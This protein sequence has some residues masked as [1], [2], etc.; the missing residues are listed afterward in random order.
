MLLASSFDMMNE[1]F[2]VASPYGTSLTC[3][4]IPVLALRGAWQSPS[5]WR[6]AGLQWFGVVAL[7]A[8]HLVNYGIGMISVPLIGV[9][10]LASPSPA[11]YRLL[12]LSIM[13][14]VISHLAPKVL[15]QGY[16]THVE[17][18]PSWFGITHFGAS[19]WLSTA[20][21][22]ALSVAVPVLV[23]FV[24]YATRGT[25]RAGRTFTVF[26]AALAVTTIIALHW[27]RSRGTSLRTRSASGSSVPMLLALLA[28]GGIGRWRTLR[29]CVPKRPE[30]AAMFVV[31]SLLALVLA[32]GRLADFGGHTPDILEPKEVALAYAVAARVSAL[33]LDGISGDYWHVWPAVLAAE[34]FRYERGEKGPGLFGITQRGQVRREAL[35]A[36]LAARGTMRLACIDYA[37]W[38][39][40]DEADAIARVGGLEMREFAVS[41]TTVGD[42]RLRFIEVSIPTRP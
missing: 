27:R 37:A 19:I 7:V 9:L 36:R 25:L 42:H 4:A 14:I 34:Q 15:A 11:R 1:T 31:V 12:T 21:G 13:A 6:R 17:L 22:F 41:E 26:V 35:L 3:G 33:S 39:C 40:L 8:A 10:T 32:R 16:F 20:W 2:V 24:L 28:L 23:A 5:G 30:R 18:R 29:H 38:Q